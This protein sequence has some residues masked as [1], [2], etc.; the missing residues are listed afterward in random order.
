MLS[1][2]PDRRQCLLSQHIPACLRATDQAPALPLPLLQVQR[3]PLIRC[4]CCRVCKAGMPLVEN[5]FP[6]I[7]HD[8]S[9]FYNYSRISH[10]RLV[11]V[12]R[13]LCLAQG[14]LTR[15]S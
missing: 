13:L 6:L 2:F 8:V 4:A 11:P 10:R 5:G 1:S 14:S 7:V 15:F 9:A 3:V 12:S